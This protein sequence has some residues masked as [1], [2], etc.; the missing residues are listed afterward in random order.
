MLLGP[1][2]GRPAR[3]VVAIRDELAA[4]EERFSRS[5]T[6]SRV[7]NISCADSGIRFADETHPVAQGGVQR[8]RMAGAGASRPTKALL[9]LWHLDRPLVSGLDLYS[10]W[11][12]G[13]KPV[14]S[15]CEHQQPGSW[16]ECRRRRQGSKLPR[17]GSCV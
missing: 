1:R 11:N 2:M 16:H 3:F 8:A 13:R 12:L 17:S 4:E 5:L 9:A 10:R 14:A 15:Q 6:S 7:E